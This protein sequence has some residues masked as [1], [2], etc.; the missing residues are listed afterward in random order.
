[1]YNTPI[2]TILSNVKPHIGGLFKKAVFW[3]LL[4]VAILVL[5]HL[6]SLN[7]N[8]RSGV[9]TASEIAAIGQLLK[10]PL[11]LPDAIASGGI[12][13]V[14]SSSISSA[15]TTPAVLRLADGTAI[16]GSGGPFHHPKPI[17]NRATR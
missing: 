3:P 4:L 9:Y 10:T 8:V 7:M 1:L 2:R 12:V 16:L 17:K 6:A 11:S 14:S 13:P 5:A 15:S